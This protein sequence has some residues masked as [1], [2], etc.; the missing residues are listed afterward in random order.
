MYNYDTIDVPQI[1]EVEEYDNDMLQ[2][3]NYIFFKIDQLSSKID[4]IESMLQQQQQS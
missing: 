4:N 2:I 3:K 1:D